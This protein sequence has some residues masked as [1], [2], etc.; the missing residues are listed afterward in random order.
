M[1]FEQIEAGGRQPNL[2]VFVWEI[3]VTKVLKNHC[4][5]FTGLALILTN[6][7]IGYVIHTAQLRDSVLFVEG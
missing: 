2:F 4:L 1:L 6:L 5:R 7:E 3:V